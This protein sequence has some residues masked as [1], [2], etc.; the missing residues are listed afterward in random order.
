MGLD[1]TGRAALREGEPANLGFWLKSPPWAGEEGRGPGQR[2][3]KPSLS[4]FTRLLV[5]RGRI[6]GT[7]GQDGDE[8]LEPLPR[9]SGGHEPGFA[10][11]PPPAHTKTQGTVGTG[12][13]SGR[14]G[15]RE[16]GGARA[17]WVL[18]PRKGNSDRPAA[19]WESS[20]GPSRVRRLRSTD[21][22][23]SHSLLDAGHPERQTGRDAT[24]VLPPRRRPRWNSSR[25]LGLSQAS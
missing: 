5:G 14:L 7:Q 18:M 12:G 20:P 17:G 22:G 19:G 6:Q 1:K 23:A 25:R 11:A 13:H 8:G 15:A 24:T 3:E 9:A 2:L 4:G 21:A 10:T 16:Q